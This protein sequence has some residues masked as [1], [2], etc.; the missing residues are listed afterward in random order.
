MSDYIQKIAIIVERGNLKTQ[1]EE[2]LREILSESIRE[3]CMNSAQEKGDEDSKGTDDAN[4]CNTLPDLLKGLSKL[5]RIL[6]VVKQDI[7]ES[8]HVCGVDIWTLFHMPIRD[9][10]Q[11]RLQ[12]EVQKGENAL[13]KASSD[14]SEPET[15]ARDGA[16]NLLEILKW[17]TEY[18]RRLLLLLELL[19]LLWLLL[20]LL[21][22]CPLPCILTL[23]GT[24]L[25]A[26][27]RPTT[28][29]PSCATRSSVAGVRLKS[30][31]S[32]SLGRSW[33]W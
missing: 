14:K 23:T 30:P 4:E 10:I 8:F 9:A 19:L 33:W 3:A 15:F 27:I 28:S 25:N 13:W 6:E 5:F 1:C 11:E 29:L 16:S 32:W 2:K 17:V 12:R 7:A 21:P 31:S 20:W 22:C 24:E 26:S 18:K